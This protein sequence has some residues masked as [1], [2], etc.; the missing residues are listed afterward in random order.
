VVGSDRE[1]D[2]IYALYFDKRDDDTYTDEDLSRLHDVDE[3]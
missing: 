1:G 3:L 2:I